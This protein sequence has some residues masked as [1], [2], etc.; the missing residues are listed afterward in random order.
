[1]VQYHMVLFC[2]FL[3][4]RL[5]PDSIL[6]NVNNL[7]SNAVSYPKCFNRWCF[8][9]KF[10]SSHYTQPLCGSF[11]PVDSWHPLKCK[12]QPG[13]QHDF[14]SGWDDGMHFLFLTVTLVSILFLIRI[15]CGHQP[16]LSGTSVF[17]CGCIYG[18]LLAMQEMRKYFPVTETAL[19]SIKKRCLFVK[20]IYPDVPRKERAPPMKKPDLLLNKTR[21]I[22]G[23]K[24]LS[25]GPRKVGFTP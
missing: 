16:A 14:F 15:W 18:S 2:R 17:K 19:S 11:L 3:I 22:G 7:E 23:L 24:K 13:F 10:V 6:F 4:C 5:L 25:R 1:M 9:R 8:G 20:L 12:P 21:K